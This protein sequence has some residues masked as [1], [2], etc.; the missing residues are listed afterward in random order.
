MITILIIQIIFFFENI[1]DDLT[2]TK[3][4]ADSINSD[5]GKIVIPASYRT[6]T[7][8]LGEEKNLY[9]ELIKLFD[10]N[11]FACQYDEK[12][13]KRL[14]KIKGKKGA[15]FGFIP[16]IIL[17]NDLI[18]DTETVV[19]LKR[20]GS[21]L[22]VHGFHLIDSTNIQSDLIFARKAPT[23]PNYNELDYFERNK[24]TYNNFSYT[25]DCSGFLSAAIS[26][27]LGLKSNSITSSAK[28]ALDS[29]KSLIIVSGVIYSPLYQAYKGEGRFE[30]VDSITKK[31]RIDVLKSILNE[32]PKKYTENTK[33]FISSNYE[34][35][36]SSNSGKSSFNGEA[37]IGLNG[38]LSYVLGNVS[39]TGQASTKIGRQSEFIQYN[40]YIVDQNINV[41]L[42]DITIKSLKDLIT[43]LSE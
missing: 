37:S 13:K 42:E 40:T 26:A 28:G 10:P 4:A 5:S 38:N 32:I 33:V 11:N 27:D 18:K 20:G 30:G 19:E 9:S 3:V 31:L 35:I 8:Q 7:I 41:L 1:I 43:N 25:L 16:N 14:K 21:N 6:I 2:I 29:D 15:E 24:N 39:A 34:V 22:L 23:I 12:L 36:L 17:E